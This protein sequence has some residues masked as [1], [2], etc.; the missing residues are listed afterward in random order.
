MRKL[1]KPMTSYDSCGTCLPLTNITNN[2]RASVNSSLTVNT[3][4]LRKITKTLGFRVPLL[5]YLKYM[6]LN[7]EKKEAIKL[8]V[9]SLIENSNKIEVRQEQS[10]TILN[11]PVN[12]NLVH[13]ENKQEVKQGEGQGPSIDVLREQLEVLKEENRL[14]RQQRDHYKRQVTELKQLLGRLRMYAQY[15]DIHNIRRALGVA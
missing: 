10:V 1:I 12:I 15:K 5:V 2:K 9:I 7:E 8:A 13:N 11:M 14:L 6:K 4:D 3:S